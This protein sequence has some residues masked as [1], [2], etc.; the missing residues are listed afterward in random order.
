MPWLS[1]SC[2]L[3]VVHH[4]SLIFQYCSCFILLTAGEVCWLWPGLLSAAEQLQWC[5]DFTGGVKLV[6][7]H[8]MTFCAWRGAHLFAFRRKK[9]EEW[10][11]LCTCTVAVCCANMKWGFIVTCVLFI[12]LEVL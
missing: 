10:F 9:R 6:E 11:K 3:R 7:E 1:R 8:V 5:R 2:S 12:S 4:A